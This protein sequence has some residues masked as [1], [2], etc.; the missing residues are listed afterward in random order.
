MDFCEAIDITNALLD[1]CN[2]ICG[3]QVAFVENDDIGEGELFFDFVGLVDLAQQMIGIDDGYD[4]IKFGSAPHVVVDKEGLCDRSGIGKPGGLHEDAV[5]AFDSLHQA[6]QDSDEI[7]ANVAANAAVVHF[8][9]FFVRVDDEFVVDANFP[10]FIDDDGVFLSVM[11][12]QDTVQE[13]GLAGAEIAG[14]YGDGDVRVHARL[15]FD[16]LRSRALVASL[17]L[18]ATDKP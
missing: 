8:N 3:N 14:K 16:L 18:E 10:K 6:A 9:D 17:M 12:G 4:R 5:K 1:S 15:P 7:A 2:L 13:R 11:F